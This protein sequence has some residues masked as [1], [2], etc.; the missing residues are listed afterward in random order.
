[1][2]EWDEAKNKLNQEKHGIG[3]EDGVTLFVE[4][5]NFALAYDAEPR[6]IQINQ[7]GNEYWSAIYTMRGEKIR[8]IS[9]RPTRTKEKELYREAI[10]EK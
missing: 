3:F 8:I 5:V 4:G 10:K 1:M 7:I 9:I 6:R 2:F